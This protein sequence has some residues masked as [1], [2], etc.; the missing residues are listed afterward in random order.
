M[1]PIEKSFLGTV[2]SL[3]RG[4]GGHG[5]GGLLVWVTAG[6]GSLHRQRTVQGSPLLLPIEVSPIIVEPPRRGARLVPMQTGLL[7]VG[8][9]LMWCHRFTVAF[10]VVLGVKMSP[11]IVKNMLMCLI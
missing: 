5:C 8:C 9:E 4:G 6:A 1:C 10:E 2:A 7:E 3:C 11:Y